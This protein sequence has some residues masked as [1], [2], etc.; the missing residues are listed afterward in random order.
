MMRR[1]ALLSTLTLGGLLGA[2]GDDEEEPAK[3]I[4]AA[5]EFSGE[6]KRAKLSGPKSIEAGAVR[7]NFKN[8]GKDDAGVTLLRIAGDHTPAETVEAGNAWGD[9]GKPLP[10]WIRFV[11]GASVVSPGDTFS[12]V[13]NLA[14]GNYIGVDI[15]TNEYAAFEVTG[16]GG[17]EA[18][19]PSA[20]IEAVEYSFATKGL[21][22]GRRQVRF[23]NSGKEPHFAQLGRIEPGKTIEDVRKAF[24]SERGAP[25]IEEEG[26]SSTGILDG[27]YSQ[28]IDLELKWGR[29]AFVCF[30]PD[31][32]GGPPHAFKG[33]IS[34]GVVQ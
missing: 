14:P 15:G 4:V 24:R 17:G 26:S 33:M 27:G 2:C 22:A 23:T 6:G 8:S 29:Y 20:T 3:A 31:R 13:Q 7:V 19:R 32:K 10:D 18:P 21:E 34:E 28:V 5:F 11:G 9:E 16:D 12:A 30:V 1:L 25:P